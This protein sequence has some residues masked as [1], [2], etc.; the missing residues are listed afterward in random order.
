MQA[1]ASKIICTDNRDYRELCVFHCLWSFLQQ[2]EQR[3]DAVKAKSIFWVAN[4]HRVMSRVE[5]A[6]SILISTW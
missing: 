3:I 4:V 5:L 1:G 2:L 6:L